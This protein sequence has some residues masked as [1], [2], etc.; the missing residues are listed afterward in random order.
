MNIRLLRIFALTCFSLLMTIP[1]LAEKDRYFYVYN[2]ANG[3]A[4]NSAQTI[5]CTKTGR[6]VITTMGQ[7]NFFDGQKFT[8]IDPTTEN[9][10][11]IMKY[12]GHAHIYF[13]KHHHLWL[14]KRK[15][16]SC[17][18]LYREMFADNIVD[19][20]K[21]LGVNGKVDDIFCDSQNNLWTLSGNSLYCVELKRNFTVQENLNLQ[22]LDVYKDKYL[23]LFYDNGLL[24]V[25]ELTTG[26]SVFSERAYDEKMAKKY[27]ATS[28]IRKIGS[29]FFQIRNGDSVGI[30]LKFDITK[31][32]WEKVFDTPYYL[33]NIIEHD[34]MLYIPSAYCYWIYN[35]TTKEL[36]HVERLKLYGG[37]TL[38]TDINCMEFDKQGGLWVGTEKRGLLYA[39][40]YTVPFK[41]YRWEEKEAIDLERLLNQ[42][43]PDVVTSYRDKPVNCVFRD[44]RGWDW[45]G[46][47][48]GL[49]LYRKSTVH[50]P[51]LFT[52]NEGLLNNVVHS[53]AEDH[54]HNI[55]VSTSY[56]VCC[57]VI[58]GDKV[59][60]VNRYNSW[61]G[62]PNESFV[63]GKSMILEDGTIVMQAL[64]HVLTF[65]PDKM[66]TLNDS[67]ISDIYPKLIRL[68]V[69]GIDVKTGQSLDGNVILEK[70]IT[71]VKV[72]NL[73]YNQNTISLTFSG[74]NYFRPQQTYYRVRVTGPGMSD[75][76]E[77][78]TPY[79][80][81]G[82]VD[83]SGLLHLPMP[84][85]VPG[86]Y[87]IEVQSSM[88]PDVW[89][90]T[91]YEWVIKV[92]EPW[93]RTTGVFMLFGLILFILLSIYIYLFLKNA[94]LKARRNSEEQ[95]I[96][97]RIKSFA[98]RCDA[99]SGM[100]LEP[101]VDEV[102]N[103]NL[104]LM[105]DFPPEFTKIIEKIMP[106]IVEKAPKDLSMH[107]LSGIA[108]MKLPEF[109]QLITSNIYKN[110]RPMAIQMML[111][112]ASDM[113]KN[114]MEKD[115][116]EI[117]DECGFVSPN[118]FI[119][120]FYHKYRVTPAEYRRRL[121]F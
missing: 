10:Y 80:S 32:K 48:I 93:W 50:L 25:L 9:T 39:R 54:S 83:N 20:F 12:N 82:L 7:I 101:T 111:T 84:S 62:V 44:S 94:N 56:G 114:E 100:V 110:P 29:E 58:E 57:L 90:T 28:V 37:N 19:E 79:S 76:W 34:G 73:N 98:E 72:L 107:Q 109:Y 6:M 105:T 106:V 60:Y 40:P 31:W 59:R 64:D 26:N 15:S 75:K 117:S 78:Y 112:R 21:K 85:L 119:A 61:D 96:I 52:R 99:V 86:T 118:Y 13:D 68:Y 66:A 17:V 45:V 97:K 16:L 87:T 95:N 2:A 36:E 53:V 67:S 70:A 5:K 41:T 35:L 24:D 113:L 108:G 43:V 46:T 104:M 23:L 4:D 77:V 92:N 49:Q 71:R 91:P 30:L 81:G 116:A 69:N 88:L 11:P 120:S 18:D 22:E 42:K 1:S 103:Q 89:K 55:W 65:N 47:S 102:S 63:N 51:E 3:L 27:S 14:K 121:L 115:I 8:Y 38:V 74:L 33:S